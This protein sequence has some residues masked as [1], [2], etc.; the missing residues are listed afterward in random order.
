[1]TLLVH[2]GF[3]TLIIAGLVLGF[4]TGCTATKNSIPLLGDPQENTV[5]A[6]SCADA[7]NTDTRQIPDDEFFRILNN[8]QTGDW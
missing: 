4:L 1:M 5:E 2:K 7:L 6:L 3:H 8:S